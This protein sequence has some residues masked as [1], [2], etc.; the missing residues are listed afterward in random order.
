MRTAS[1]P[2]PV[3]SWEWGCLWQRGNWTRTY[4]QNTVAG[5]EA[6]KRRRGASCHLAYLSVGGW[7][8]ALARKKL[9]QKLLFCIVLVF[10]LLPRD[11]GPTWCGSDEIRSARYWGRH[12][13]SSITAR[14]R[15]MSWNRHYHHLLLRHR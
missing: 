8:I 15:Q 11:R 9:K 4:L 14:W 2:T 3:E 6:A 5:S 1:Q 12:G 10:S 7:D 13:E